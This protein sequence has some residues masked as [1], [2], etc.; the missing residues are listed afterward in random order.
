MERR[1]RDRVAASR[2]RTFVGRAA[3]REL[4]RAG[5]VADT[6]SGF[7]VLFVQGDGGVGKSALL[8]M[9]ADQAAEAGY[10]VV[11]IDGHDVRPNSESF[12]QVA[13]PGVGLRLGSCPGRHLR[14][15]RAAG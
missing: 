10:A 8:R 5:L 15:A 3:E 2:Q 9:Y 4:F 7:A 6:G 13:G 14:V 11:R 1:L 12:L